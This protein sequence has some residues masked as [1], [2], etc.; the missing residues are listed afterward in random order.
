MPQNN[1][2]SPAS[3][4]T[5]KRRVKNTFRQLFGWDRREPFCPEETRTALLELARLHP[6]WLASALISGICDDQI[7]CD[8][9]R[10]ARACALLAAAQLD[11]TA[12][13]CQAPEEL[14][15]ISK[16]PVVEVVLKAAIERAPDR[17]AKLLLL[18]RLGMH[19]ARCGDY[20][21]AFAAFLEMA[22]NEPGAGEDGRGVL[23]ADVVRRARRSARLA[24]INPRE[25]EEQLARIDERE[26]RRKELRVLLE[27]YP[28]DVK[29]EWGSDDDFTTEPLRDDVAA[30]TGLKRMERYRFRKL[31]V[32]GLSPDA[33]QKDHDGYVLIVEARQGGKPAFFL[34]TYHAPDGTFVFDGRNGGRCHLSSRAVV[35]VWA[36]IIWKETANDALTEEHLD[37]ARCFLRSIEP[38][39]LGLWGETWIE[40]NQETHEILERTE[41]WV[42]NRI[43]DYL[44]SRG[45]KVSEVLLVNVQHALQ[46]M[47]R[48]MPGA[49]R[50]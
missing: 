7:R 28:S 13:Y 37:M 16:A 36:S 32:G 25:F 49:G 40:C 12:Q 19:F 43:G 22:K 3:L 26:R 35:R 11:V 30:R 4:S 18:R 33:M 21:R 23:D 9:P 39:T 48:C 10:D 1:T 5:D 42:L 2:D 14:Q 24:G 8:L 6:T 38:Q 46:S 27:R 50:P 29:R 34:A 15:E 47:S 20:A 41:A 31:A 45:L 44:H 17:N